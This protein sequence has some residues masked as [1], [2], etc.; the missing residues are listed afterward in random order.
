MFLT[1]LTSTVCLV[2]NPKCIYTFSCFKCVHDESNLCLCQGKAVKYNALSKWLGGYFMDH[3]VSVRRRAK[4]NQVI[5]Y[6]E[7]LTFYIL[8]FF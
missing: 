5:R 8:P 1:C 2:L 7:G 6:A 4:K 3:W